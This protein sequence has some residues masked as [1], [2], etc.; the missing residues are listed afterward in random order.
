MVPTGSDGTFINT[1]VSKLSSEF[2]LHDLGNLSQFIG[3]EVLPDSKGLL[4]MQ[5]SYILGLFKKLGMSNCKTCSSPMVA[6]KKLKLL[7][8]DPL[9]PTEATLIDLF[10]GDYNML[11]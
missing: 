5:R 11:L 1:I 8:G 2:S 4:L 7:N 6:T 10:V 9:T 3:L